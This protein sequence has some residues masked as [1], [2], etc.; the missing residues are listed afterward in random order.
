MKRA[1]IKSTFPNYLRAV[2]WWEKRK[3]IEDASFKGCLRYSFAS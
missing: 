3:K 2:T 1:E